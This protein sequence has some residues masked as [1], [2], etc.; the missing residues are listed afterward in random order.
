MTLGFAPPRGPAAEL[1]PFVLTRTQAPLERLLAELAEILA[2]IP[3]DAMK[4]GGFS[5][6]FAKGPEGPEAL[7]YLTVLRLW[8]NG[9]IALKGLLSLLQSGRRRPGKLGR[10]HDGPDCDLRP[11]GVKITDLTDPR[12]ENAQVGPGS[13]IDWGRA[14]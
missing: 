7:A 11:E 9:E 2:T 6:A 1:A 4:E 8:T 12:I 14:R 10:I 5:R 13:T 3:R